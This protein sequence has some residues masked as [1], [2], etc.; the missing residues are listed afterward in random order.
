V[1]SLYR[2]VRDEYLLDQQINAVPDLEGPL[3]PQSGGWRYIKVES[4]VGI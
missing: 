4:L 3:A 2:P 1:V